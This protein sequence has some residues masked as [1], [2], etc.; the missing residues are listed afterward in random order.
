MA[1][2]RKIIERVRFLPWKVIIG[3]FAVGLAAE[4]KDDPFP[5]AIL[6]WAAMYLL[7]PAI[8][9]SFFREWRSDQS[10]ER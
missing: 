6:F 7:L 3:L 10:E 1:F 5:H 2:I 8:A 4:M 9:R